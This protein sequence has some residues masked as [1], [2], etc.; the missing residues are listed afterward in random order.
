MKCGWDEKAIWNSPHSLVW[1]QNDPLRILKTKTYLAECRVE[2]ERKE[3]IEICIRKLHFQFLR[4]CSPWEN[5]I[6]SSASW[7]NVISSEWLVRLKVPYNKPPGFQL[8]SVSE[9]YFA[10]LWTFFLLW[11]DVA[12][13][14][15]NIYHFGFSSVGQEVSLIIP[16]KI[17]DSCRKWRGKRT[18][19]L[20]VLMLRMSPLQFDCHPDLS[21][22]WS[23]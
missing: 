11:Q 10:V 12:Y 3:R 9:K 18:C 20:L 23:E 21:M 16:Q 19:I 2:N 4:C 1:T 8:T 13:F 17:K 7:W 6:G 22:T 15:V 14:Y 5:V